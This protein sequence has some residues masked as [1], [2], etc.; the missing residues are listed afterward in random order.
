MLFA[1]PC[2]KDEEV[3]GKGHVDERQ[4]G[5]VRMGESPHEPAGFVAHIQVG[6]YLEAVEHSRM[7]PKLRTREVP[8]IP[9]EDARRQLKHRMAMMP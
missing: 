5:A 1:E 2:W 6:A 8:T 4:H 9:N 7:I 3:K